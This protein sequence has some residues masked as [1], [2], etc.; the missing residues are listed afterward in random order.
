[1]VEV[2]RRLAADTSAF[3]SRDQA[4]S[5][6]RT[7]PPRMIVSVV[8]PEDLADQIGNS[9]VKGGS[10]SRSAFVLKLVRL[11]FSAYQAKRDLDKSDRQEPTPKAKT[12]P[13]EDGVDPGGSRYRCA[14]CGQ[15][16]VLQKAGE[17]QSLPR[18][19]VK[20][21]GQACPGNYRYAQKVE[22]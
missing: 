9:R 10:T 3:I 19:H 20:A 4:T 5:G 15:P 11:G 2:A 21:N 14:V 18:R 17:P 6:S 7:V 8:L 16:V 12:Q 22:D 1:M 13:N